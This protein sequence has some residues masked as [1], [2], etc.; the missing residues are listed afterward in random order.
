M[1][2][3]TWS[4]LIRDWQFYFSHNS[5]FNPVTVIPADGSQLNPVINKSWEV[6]T[7]W[8][9][10]GNRFQASMAAR[11]IQDLN[12]VV[13]ISTGVYEQVGKASTYNIDFDA[14]GD[15]THGFSMIATYAYADSLIDRLRSDG[16]PQTNGGKRFPQAPKHISRLMAT[17]SFKLGETT[18]LNFSLGG[19]YVRHYF[20]NTANTA[21]VPSATTFDGAISLQRNKY[22]VQVNFANLLNAQRYFTSVINSTQL[23]PGTPITATLTVRYRF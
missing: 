19:Y 17:K 16:V 22:D 13:T 23:Y 14:K 21:I 10:F 15:L 18:R 2:L 11:R 8:R 20:T 7:R 5:S 4:P 6:G 1:P 9:G 12:R 3:E